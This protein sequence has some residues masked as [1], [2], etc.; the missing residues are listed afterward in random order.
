MATI[1]EPKQ[2]IATANDLQSVII[3]RIC[4]TR[5]GLKIRRVACR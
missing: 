3:V 4:Q 2:K 5:A 1:E